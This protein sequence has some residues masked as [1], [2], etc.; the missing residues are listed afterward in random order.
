MYKRKATRY[1]K[2]ISSANLV[3]KANGELMVPCDSTIL[4]DNNVEI[5]L[6]KSRRMGESFKI[7]Y[8]NGIRKAG[9]LKNAAVSK[10]GKLTNLESGFYT[11]YIV[12]QNKETYLTYLY[13]NK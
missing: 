6:E 11:L 3:L 9:S 8:K 5:V 10:D 12:T 4:S 13:I 1:V 2:V 7:Y